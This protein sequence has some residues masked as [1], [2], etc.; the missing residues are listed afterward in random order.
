M[1]P[2][3]H[4]IL[5]KLGFNWHTFRKIIFGSTWYGGFELA[6]LYL[7]QGYLA[8]K[9]FIGHV[10]EETLMGDQIIIALS[11]AQLT[12]GS[13]HSLLEEVGNDRSYVQANWLSNIRTF[14]RCCKASIIVPGAWRPVAQR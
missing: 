11:K 4:A 10:R 5:P 3:V 14:L 13:G 12:S 8:I 2:F 1:K 7:T 6:H 9:H